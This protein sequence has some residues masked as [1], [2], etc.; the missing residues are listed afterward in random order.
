MTF[1]KGEKIALIGSNGAGKSTLMKLLVGLLK[2]NKGSN[3]RCCR[4]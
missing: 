1:R 3:P 4:A 2:P